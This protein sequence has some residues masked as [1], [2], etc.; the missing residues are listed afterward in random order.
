[1]AVTPFEPAIAGFVDSSG[2]PLAGGKVLTYA[3]GTT[4][5]KATY[6][7]RTD[8]ENAT[9]PNANPVI[10]D[11]RGAASIWTAATGLY[12][13]VVTDADDVE[14]TTIDEYGDE[15][16]VNVVPKDYIAG[17]KVSTGTDTDHDVDISAGECRDTADSHDIVVTT[18]LTVAIDASGING[19]DTGAVAADTMYALWVVAD[20]SGANAV[21]GIYSLS[22][23]NPT[24]PSGYDKKRMISA[25][26]TDGSS[27]VI[28]FEQFGDYFRYTGDLIQDVNDNT[29]TGNA[30]ATGT[31]SAPPGCVAHITAYAQNGTDDNIAVWV[32]PSGAADSASPDEAAS[33]VQADSVAGT[34]TAGMEFVPVDSSSQMQYAATEAAGTT[35]V[36]INTRG[37]VMTTRG[38]P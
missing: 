24:L 15:N 10:L 3:E 17:L 27:N 4:T 22:F 9:S 2:N 28:A 32:R 14:V 36:I 29:I 6:P 16:D 8:A 13:F 38:D 35:V 18:P 20:A 11:A 34:Q 33:H 19:L 7:T 1:M 25:H 31:L 12:Y 5:A 26:R 37:F 21:G 30:F 23:D